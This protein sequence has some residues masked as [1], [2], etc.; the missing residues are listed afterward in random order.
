[1]AQGSCGDFALCESVRIT[2]LTQAPE[3]TNHYHQE[4]EPFFFFLFCL[5]PLTPKGRA[6]PHFPI[7]YISISMQSNTS[8][9]DRDE[10]NTEQPAEDLAT[11]L[12][13]PFS[14]LHPGAAEAQLVSV[15]GKW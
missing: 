6:L 8:P 11:G 1:M 3:S 13:P 14:F 2:Q 15:P 4:A 5:V 12:P 7:A 10:Q 9:G